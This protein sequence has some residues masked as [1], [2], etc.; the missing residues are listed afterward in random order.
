MKKPIG[1]KPGGKKPVAKKTGEP[2]PPRL[3]QVLASAGLGSRRECETLI[4]EGRVEVDGEIA[5]KLGTRADPETQAIFVDGEPVKVERSQYFLMNKPV[6][7]VCTSRD[8][9]GRTRVIDL[10]RADAR[11]YCVGRLD[12]TSEGLI[13]VT[14]DGDLANRLTHPSF[15]IEK[16]YLVEVAGV[17]T[18]EQ[19]EELEKGVHLA[20][21]YAKAK[22]IRPRRTTQR[23]TI[24][25]IVLNEGRNREIR[26]LL[27]R[28]GHKVLRL[29]RIAIGPILLGELAPGNSRRLTPEE[30][31]LLKGLSRKKKQSTVSERKQKEIVEQTMVSEFRGK[32]RKRRAK[33]GETA[34]GKRRI[35]SRALSR[36]KSPGSRDSRSD[37]ARRGSSRPADARRGATRQGSDRQSDSRQSGTREGVSRRGAARNS[38]S[39]TNASASR[40]NSPRRK[41]AR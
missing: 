39:R 37:D 36:Q 23:G 30:L 25:E 4:V 5:D 14:N 1:K 2:K 29:K 21:G 38:P 20:E 33:P 31:D 28:I 26:R 9:S 12:R 8:P 10:I 3:Q 7:V 32:N 15:E 34:D 11:I 24:L 18:L 27:A 22:S 6:G 16:R 13:L 41:P 17:P 40:S 19:L 35:P